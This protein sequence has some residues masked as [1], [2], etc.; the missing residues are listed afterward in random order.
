MIAALGR[1]GHAAPENGQDGEDKQKNRGS[2]RHYKQ[3]LFH[4][5]TSLS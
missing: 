3:F 1:G 2:R 4:V 5:A